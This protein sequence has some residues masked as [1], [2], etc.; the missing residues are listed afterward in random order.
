MATERGQPVPGF[1]LEYE[2]HSGPWKDIFDLQTD[3][4]KQDIR[5]ARTENR[6][7]VYLSCPISARGG[8]YSTT[9]IDVAK[10]TVRSLLQKWG[11]GFWILNPAQYQLESKAGTGLM[12]QHA[13]TLG[14]DLNDLRRVSNPPRAPRTPSGGDYMRMWTRVLVENDE[15]WGFEVREPAVLNT[16]QHFDAFY[17]LGPRDVQAFFA[18]EQLSLTAGIES[19]FARLYAMDADFCDTFAVDGITWGNKGEAAR[20]QGQEQLRLRDLWTRQRMEFVRY[21]GLRASGNFS[22][23]SHDE[24]NIFCKINEARR[25]A[26]IR[27]GQL[28]GDVGVQLAGFFDG[29]Q[30]DPASTETGVTRGY[31]L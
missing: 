9:N 7:I 11:E 20:P 17:F 4:I 30:L 19:Y 27:P 31:A 23:G 2:W 15:P 18:Q 5:R 6:L 24:W 26:T 3:L 10:F 25:R 1:P 14:I 12:E 21:Y 13:K 22:L 29:G 16:G 8:G 28:D